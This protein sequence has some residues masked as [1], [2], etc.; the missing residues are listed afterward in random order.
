MEPPYLPGA[1]GFS[2]QENA[3]RYAWKL[4]TGVSGIFKPRRRYTATG[5]R[6]MNYALSGAVSPSHPALRR[7]TLQG[8][9]CVRFSAAMLSVGGCSDPHSYPTFLRSRTVMRYVSWGLLGAGLSRSN[10]LPLHMPAHGF[11]LANST[12]NTQ[13]CFTS[14]PRQHPFGSGSGT[15]RRV[16]TPLNAGRLSEASPSIRF[17]HFHSS[18]Y[19]CGGIRT[20]VRS[21][22][23]RDTFYP[24]CSLEC[25]QRWPLFQPP[26][27]MPLESYVVKETFRLIPI[28]MSERCFYCFTA[29]VGWGR[30]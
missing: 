28:A 29:L 30:R 1:T 9:Q 16:T 2:T 15:V 6:D 25:H 23:R 7:V 12:T 27:L 10:C 21:G 17:S 13:H 3:L 26:T 20:R 14:P 5:Y 4:S 11:D 19:S 22:F 18:C 24:C 8:M